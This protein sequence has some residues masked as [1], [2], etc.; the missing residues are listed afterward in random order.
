MRSRF[1]YK[2]TG[3]NELLEDV[4]LIAEMK[5]LKANPN[6]RAKGIVIEASLKKVLVPLQRCLFR[7]VRSIRETRSSSARLWAESV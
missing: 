2:K 4:L 6:R 3:I 1:G 7:T 5:E